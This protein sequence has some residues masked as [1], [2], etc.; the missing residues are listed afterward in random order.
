MRRRSIF[1]IQTVTRTAIVL[2]VFSL[3]VCC[4]RDPELHLFDGGEIDTDLPLVD[5]DL[6]TY[7]DYDFETEYDVAVSW[8]SEWFYGWDEEDVRIF[9]QLGYTEPSTLQLRR[10][11]TGSEPYTSHT[12]VLSH[13]ITGH[14]FRANY[15]WGFW[16]I[17]TWNDIYTPDGVQSLIFDEQTSLDSVIAYTNQSMFHT[18]YNSPEFTHSFYQPEEL[19]SAYEQ[20]IEIN[21]DLRGFEFDPIRNVYV[22]KLNMTLEPITYIYLTQVI[23]HN[24]HNRITGT[25]GQGNLSGFG[26][27]TVLNNGIAGPD[28]ITVYF[29]NRFKANC[30]REDEYVDIVGGRMLTFGIVGQNMNRIKNRSEVLDKVPHY[31]DV[32]LLFNNGMDSTFVF[33]VTEQ[34][35]SHWRGGVITVDLDM[36]T[37]RIP[38]RK[39]GSA[40]DAVVKEFEEETHEIEM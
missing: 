12:S 13:T 15:N 33:D 35:R 38:T 22:K 25:D 17:L 5:I 24:N 6:D 36:D 9:G 34:V 16:D 3:L 11:F 14:S 7:W 1:D 20:G 21:R 29:N 4:I 32:T 37:V 31:L 40:F 18:R 10:Y 27:T 39:G 19:F 2:A 26:R 8:E 30:K 28:V 23:I